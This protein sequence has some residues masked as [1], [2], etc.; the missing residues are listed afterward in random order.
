[1]EG[2]WFTSNLFSVEPGEDEEINPGRYGRQLALWLREQLEKRGYNVEPVIAEDWGR[3]LM[4]SRKPFLLWVACGNVD[5]SMEEDSSNNRIIWHCFPSAEV[6]L[7]KRLFTR[8][9]TAA[10]LSK[11][12]ADL[13]A[14]LIAEPAI[15]W[16][17]EP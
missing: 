10:A 12:D 14:I 2:Y 1:M 16:V 15:T 5:E 13:H 7:L 6:P 9:D 11:L 4:L 17:S 8:P 3:C